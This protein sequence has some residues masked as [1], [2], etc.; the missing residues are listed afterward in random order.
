[1]GFHFLPSG[2]QRFSQ[3]EIENEDDEDDNIGWKRTSG[4]KKTFAIKINIGFFPISLSSNLC[5]Y[6]Q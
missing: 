5:W 3:Y 4:E 1:M 6:P 2:T